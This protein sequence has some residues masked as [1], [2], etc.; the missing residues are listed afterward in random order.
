MALITIILD[1]AMDFVS[2]KVL[3]GSMRSSPFQVEIIFNQL[4]AC[5]RLIGTLLRSLEKVKE[6]KGGITLNWISNLKFS[7]SLRNQVV[8]KS[9]SNSML[10]N[11]SDFVTS[12]RRS[13]GSSVTPS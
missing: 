9:S 11:F 6:T 10:S 13:G 12:G 2:I 4:L 8:S 5:S 1:I 3:M 7:I